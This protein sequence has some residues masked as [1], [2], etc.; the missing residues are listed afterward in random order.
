[1][2]V[3]IFFSTENPNVFMVAPFTTRDLNQRCMS[4]VIFDLNEL[5]ALYPDI[6]KESFRQFINIQEPTTSNGYV[7][8]KLVTT[9]D[10]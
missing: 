5:K 6:P 7:N 2:I 8:H 9:V 3:I 4:D 1:M 10:G